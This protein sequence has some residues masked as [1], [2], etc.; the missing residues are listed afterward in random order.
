MSHA[1]LEEVRLLTNLETSTEQL[2]SIVLVGQVELAE[3][4]N[5]P[6][7]HQLKQ[8]VALRSKLSPL[9][10]QEATAYIAERIRSPAATSR[11][12]SAATPSR[13]STN[14][15][16]ESRGR[17]AS[18]ATTRWYRASRSINARSA[19]RSSRKCRAISI[20]RR[21]AGECRAGDGTSASRGSGQTP[22]KR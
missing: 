9:T 14:A 5:E 7:L 8:R 21:L 11:P 2:L 13:R 17:S 4:L 16:G 3:R 12:S 6:K 10:A 1:L 22:S 18:S 15:P 19:G 20:S